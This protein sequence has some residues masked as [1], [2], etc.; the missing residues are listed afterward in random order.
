MQIVQQVS[1]MTRNITKLQTL[2]AEKEGFVGLAHTRLGHRTQRPNLELI[3]D[4]VEHSL[5]NELVELK[6]MV[7]SLQQSLRNVS[8]LIHIIYS[9]NK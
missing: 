7:A 4:S 9:H 2:I 1:E 3:C 8:L 5:E 6:K